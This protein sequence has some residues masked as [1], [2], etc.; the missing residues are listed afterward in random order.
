MH[1]QTGLLLSALALAVVIPGRPLLADHVPSRRARDAAAAAKVESRLVEL[2]ATR[3]A[4][5]EQLASLTPQE[6]SFFAADP[7]RVQ[8][9]SGLWAEEW[10]MGGG[11][12][13]LIL[14]ITAGLASNAKG[15]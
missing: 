10:L 15:V 5:S 6:I 14:L 9:V 2:G 4:A 11:F 8:V 3:Q 13:G 1:K 12:L 7:S